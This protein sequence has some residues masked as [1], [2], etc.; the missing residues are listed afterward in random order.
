MD[1]NEPPVWV[2]ILPFYGQNLV[3]YN[4]KIFVSFEYGLKLQLRDI[5]LCVK[6]SFFTVTD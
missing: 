6:E 1:R 3:Y 2:L 4:K 5:W